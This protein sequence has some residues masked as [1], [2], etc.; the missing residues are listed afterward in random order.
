LLGLR[1]DGLFDLHLLERLNRLGGRS[2]LG[3]VAIDVI[4]ASPSA[5]PTW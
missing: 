4:T 2:A 3:A 1:G 5:D